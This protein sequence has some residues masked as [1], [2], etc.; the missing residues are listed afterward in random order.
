MILGVVDNRDQRFSN[1]SEPRTLLY[2][3][4]LPTD[5]KIDLLYKLGTCFCLGSSFMHISLSIDL[6]VIGTK[7]VHAQRGSRPS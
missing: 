1:L 7:F 5:P 2:V 3:L 4:C 6:F